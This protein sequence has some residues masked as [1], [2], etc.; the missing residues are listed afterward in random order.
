VHLAGGLQGIWTIYFNTALLA[1][2]DERDHCV[3]G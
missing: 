3:R 1:K 2:L